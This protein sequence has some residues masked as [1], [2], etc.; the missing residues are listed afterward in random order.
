MNDE[1]KIVKP[2]KGGGFS[3]SP[4]IIIVVL[5]AVFLII[6]AG[7]SFFVVDQTEQAVVLRLGRYNR[8][9][10]P[11]LSVSNRATQCRHSS[12]RP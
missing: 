10:G 4:K 3:F 6:A 2:A 1:E 11:G 9:V 8:T 7:S 12:C 5:I